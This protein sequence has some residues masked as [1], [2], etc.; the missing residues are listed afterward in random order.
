[1]NGL[2]QVEA[3]ARLPTEDKRLELWVLSL[4]CEDEVEPVWL[5][6]RHLLVHERER[7]RQVLVPLY[8][9]LP[10]RIHVV[11]LDG[12]SSHVVKRLGVHPDG[13]EEALDLDGAERRRVEDVGPAELALVDGR[14]GWLDASWT[15]LDVNERED[16]VRGQGRQVR[17]GEKDELD[18]E[19]AEREEL[20]SAQHPLWPLARRLGGQREE[21]AFGR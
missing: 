5:V 20:S 4:E 9:R 21:R 10:P 17:P 6:E 16:G 13:P 1:M 19:Q 7:A 3:K 18:D 11:S 15:A 12:C 8:K 2:E 14:L